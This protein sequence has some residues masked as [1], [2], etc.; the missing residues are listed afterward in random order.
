MT[1]WTWVL[2]GLAAAGLLLAWYGLCA[3]LISAQRVRRHVT[4]I[5]RSQFVLSLESLGLQGNRL[6]SIGAAMNVQL[7]RLLRGFPLPAGSHAGH[8]GDAEGVG[9]GLDAGHRKG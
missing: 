7:L 2:V 1:I 3:A 5:R 8:R 9:R 4:A 6:A